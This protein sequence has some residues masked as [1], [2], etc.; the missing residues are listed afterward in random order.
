MPG[1]HG[2]T[3]PPRLQSLHSARSQRKTSFA[4]EAMRVG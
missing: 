1:N 2:V 3:T 4:V